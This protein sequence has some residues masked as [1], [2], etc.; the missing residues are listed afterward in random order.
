ME[1]LAGRS[2]GLVR[3]ALKMKSNGTLAWV[4][5]G[6]AA[7][8][9]RLA[10]VPDATARDGADRLQRCAAPRIAWLIW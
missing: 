2:R 9:S 5:R 10:C 6:F 7:E 3:L 8:L 1:M 4:R